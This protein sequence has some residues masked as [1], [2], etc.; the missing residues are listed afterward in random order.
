MLEH[1]AVAEDLAEHFGILLN[2]R[3]VR[4]DVDH[5][6]HP[7]LHCVPQRESER[8]D[9]FSAAGRYGQRVDAF[10]FTACV[11][12]AIQYLTAQ[13]IESGFG[14]LPRRDVFFQPF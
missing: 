12:T 10:W 4:H 8:R 7:V 2:D 14:I 5:T 13:L 9:R 11:Y 6:L 3:R 1:I